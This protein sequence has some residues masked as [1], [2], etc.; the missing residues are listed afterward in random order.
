MTSNAHHWRSRFLTRMSLR[1][2]TV[3]S[4]ILL[5][6]LLREILGLMW[7]VV[8]LPEQ[9]AIIVWTPRE[10]DRYSRTDWNSR[11]MVRTQANPDEWSGTWELTL[12][13]RYFT[14]KGELLDL[15]CGAGR[16]ALLLARLG[17]TVTACDWSPR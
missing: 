17:L 11:T 13:E 7:R 16:E 6:R 8:S 15:A 3:Y 5:T 4:F 10:I 9:F 14:H 12:V 2:S 1:Y